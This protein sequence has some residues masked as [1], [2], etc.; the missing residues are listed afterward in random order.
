VNGIVF[1]SIGAYTLLASGA[2]TWLQVG[3]NF[4]CTE[5]TQSDVTALA[6]P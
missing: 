6:N 3:Y 2:I 5:L 1:G 4:V